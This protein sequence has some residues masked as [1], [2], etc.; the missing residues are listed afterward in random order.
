[1]SAT[2]FQTDIVCNLTQERTASEYMAN[3]SVIRQQ[4]KIENK[5]KR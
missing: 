2:R 1:M 4:P 3:N 5:L